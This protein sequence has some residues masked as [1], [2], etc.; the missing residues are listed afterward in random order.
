[1]T[2]PNQRPKDDYTVDELIEMLTEY[3]DIDPETRG[4]KKV[5][6]KTTNQLRP[7]STY[8]VVFNPPYAYEKDKRFQI[9][10]GGWTT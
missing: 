7:A 10:P 8:K 2:A 9:F 6:F 1:M 4:K 3:R 5:V